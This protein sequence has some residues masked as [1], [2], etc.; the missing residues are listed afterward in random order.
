MECNLWDGRFGLYSA[1]CGVWSVQCKVWSVKRE[2][3]KSGVGR[4]QFEVLS[5]KL[6]GFVGAKESSVKSGM[7]CG[8]SSK[9]GWS[10]ECKVKRVQCDVWSVQSGVKSVTAGVWSVQG[11]VTGERLWV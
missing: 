11:G 7:A 4:M 6:G 9:K 2:S 1:K 3:V 10:V 8:V 5:T